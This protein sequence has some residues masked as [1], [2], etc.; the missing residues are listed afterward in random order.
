MSPI[1]W[2]HHQTA[3]T[4][5]VLRLFR[6]SRAHALWGLPDTI[7]LS[8]GRGTIRFRAER[9]I[10]FLDPYVLEEAHHPKISH[11]ITGFSGSVANVALGF[12]RNP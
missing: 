4:R 12:V 5:A 9:D 2:L 3:P 11:G 7:A 6:D 1:E 10:L 8:K